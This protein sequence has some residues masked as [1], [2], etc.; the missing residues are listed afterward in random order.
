MNYSRVLSPLAS[1]SKHI[2]QA[3]KLIDDH[4]CYEANLALKAISDPL[5]PPD[6]RTSG[7]RSR[8]AGNRKRD[9]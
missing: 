4:K 9:K 7:A 6:D 3:I 2:E 5:P 8:S 1:T